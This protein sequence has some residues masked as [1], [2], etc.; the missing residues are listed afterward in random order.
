[1]YIFQLSQVIAQQLKPI[2]LV[3]AKVNVVRIVIA[4]EIRSVVEMAAVVSAVHLFSKV[5]PS[6][7]K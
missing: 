4:E 3:S 5:K 6:N 1:M 7:K 2:M